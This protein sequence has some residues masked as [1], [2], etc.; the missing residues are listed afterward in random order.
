[1]LAQAGFG[2]GGSVPETNPD[3]A[4]E[5][6]DRDGAVSLDACVGSVLSDPHF[7][8]EAPFTHQRSPLASHAVSC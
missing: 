1:M 4:T 3:L 7:T 2:N 6:T 5:D 8:V